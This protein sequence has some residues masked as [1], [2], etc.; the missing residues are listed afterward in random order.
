GPDGAL[1]YVG[2][3]GG[4]V[5]RLAYLGTAQEL[6]VSPTS[7]NILE[8][9][10]GVFTVRLAASPTGN[11]TVALA[12][13]AG[14]SDLTV[15]SGPTLTF[16]PANYATPQVVYVTAAEDADT[17]N[18]SATFT[19]SSLGLTSQFVS[20][21]AVDND[22]GLLLSTSVLNINEGGSGTSFVSLSDPPTATVT[23]N[24]VRSSGDP[25]ISISTGASLTF[26]PANFSVPQGVTVSGATD[27]DT[28]DDTATVT[29]SSAGLPAV[30]VAVTVQ[31][32]SSSA[33]LITSAPLT[34]AIVGAAYSYGVNAIGAPTP[35]Y[36]LA[37][38]PAGM[39]IDAASGLIS[40]TP[41]QTGGFDVTV[42]AANGIPPD[43]LQSYTITVSPDAPPI[44]ILTRPSGG[45]V[46]SGTTAE[47]FGNGNDDVATVRAEFYVDGVLSYTDINS[48]DHFHFGGTHNLWDTTQLTNGSHDLRLV[49]YDTTGQTGSATV[50]VMV[51]NTASAPTPLVTS[52][53][54][55]TLRN[56]FNGWL[57]MRITVGASPVTVTSLGRMFYTGNNSPHSLKVVFASNGADVPGGG[58]SLNMLGGTAGQFKYAVLSSPLILAAGTSYYVI[59]LEA[60]GGDRWA[61]DNTQVTSTTAATCNGA[62]L[63]KPGG[64]TFRLPANRSFGPLNLL[65]T[66]GSSPPPNMPPTISLSSPAN[67]STFTAPAN[68]TLTATASDSDG[69]VSK[70]DFFS[71]PSL[72]ASAAT[73]PYNFVWNNVLAGN[74]NLMATATDNL[75]ASNTSATVSVT[76]SSA[77]TSTPFVTSYGQGT[78]RND[79]NGWLGMK[80]TVGPSPILVTALGRIFIAGN[81]GAHAVKLVNASN[82][83]DVPGGAVSIGMAGGTAGQ[84]TYVALANAITL[85]ANTAYYLVSQETSGGDKWATSNTTITTTPAATCNGALLSNSASWTFR[86]P[87][88][89]TFGPVNLK[90]Q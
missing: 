26:T 54:Q 36:S 10:A 74:Y 82:G 5:Y 34:S 20:V 14:D 42:Q 25:D 17:I 28:I 4:T 35:A 22:G 6:I 33:P 2:V 7:L 11:V 44:A 38:A 58:T 48:N 73:S 65:Y 83:A 1:Y 47:F 52:Y 61:T 53:L 56:D 90:Y 55:G 15:A 19:V 41:T 63:S 16:T 18:D 37:N 57:G 62:I 71:G 9:G 80:V 23:V 66:T 8:G 89:T 39:T 75:N 12:R 70:V 21:N 77:G 78:L 24:V 81:V 49:V 60:S 88:N 79:F 50:S 45:E 43:A 85:P 69:S 86:P 27:A 59:S 67:N 76:V 13:T 84:F 30:N 64:W 29:V 46:V 68:I 51:S 32:N 3:T 87:A 40:W 31:D 72:L